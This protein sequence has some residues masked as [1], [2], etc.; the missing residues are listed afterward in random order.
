MAAFVSTRLRAMQSGS[1]LERTAS[2]E[3]HPTFATRKSDHETRPSD[4][5]GRRGRA[6][7]AVEKPEVTQ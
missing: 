3:Q 2:C 5:T 7:E 1:D 6:I 4:C